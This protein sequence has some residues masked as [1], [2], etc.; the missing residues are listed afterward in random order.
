MPSLGLN[1]K[2]LIL[3]KPILGSNFNSHWYKSRFMLIAA[4]IIF[5]SIG[6][7]LIFTSRAATTLTADFNNDNIVNVFD[8]SILASNWGKTGATKATGDTNG[9]GAVNIFDLSKLAGEW[10]QTVTP[11]GQPANSINVKDYGVVGD[12][13]T[14]DTAKLL[15]AFNTAVAQAKIA[16]V[17]N[18]TYKV[19]SLTI[20]NNAQVTGQSMAGAWIKGQVTAGSNQT[21]TAFKVGDL[22]ST[23]KFAANASYTNINNVHFRGGG[24]VGV[25]DGLHQVIEIGTNTYANNYI[26]HIN[27]INCE[28]ERNL[29]EPYDLTNYSNGW[30]SN[31]V[32]ITGNARAGAMRVTDVKFEGCHFGVSNGQPGHNTGSPRM[33]VEIWQDDVAGVNQV[34]GFQHIDFINNTFEAADGTSLDYAGAHDPSTGYCLSGNSIVTGNLFKGSGYIDTHPWKSDITLEPACDM[35]ITNNTFWGSTGYSGVAIESEPSKYGYS[36]NNV[37]KNNVID[38]SVA[39]GINVDLPR[40]HFVISGINN[41][42]SYNNITVNSNRDLLTL[43]TGANNR[44]VGNNFTINTLTYLALLRF[45]LG[46]TE[47]ATN[48]PS[49]GNVITNNTFNIPNVIPE[50]LVYPGSSGNIVNSNIFRGKAMPIVTD[51][52]GTLQ[53]TNNTFTP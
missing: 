14:D 23:F 6:T 34:Q 28:I 49:T 18:G 50:I 16:W 9:D 45:G 42:F 3:H 7:Y 41:E 5:A 30:N 39:N 4:V 22:G 35:T 51:Q 44:V 48:A 20:P 43:K 15:S 36:R 37:F 53:F 38:F 17:P 8:L 33:T 19:T 40:R 12:G 2:K 29:G 24:R 52:T 11:T 10:G 13:V 32:S 46:A 26:H 47:S 21:L 27:F 1:R 25:T 31:N